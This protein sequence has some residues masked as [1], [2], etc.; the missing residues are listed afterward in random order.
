MQ[1]YLGQDY[2]YGMLMGILL[3]RKSIQI[4][5]IQ[6]S[7]IRLKSVPKSITALHLCRLMMIGSWKKAL[8]METVE[9]L[10]PVRQ[11]I[12]HSR[13]VLRQI[14]TSIMGKVVVLVLQI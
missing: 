6:K 8:A 9:T 4:Q 3:K 13:A 14:V 12:H 7:V 5:L 2:L 1:D 10:I 11:V